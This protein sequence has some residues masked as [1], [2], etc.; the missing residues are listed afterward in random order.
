MVQSVAE[1][2]Q[3]DGEERAAIEW[4]DYDEAVLGLAGLIPPGKVL[5]YGDLAEL[6]GS[7]GPRQVGKAMSRC[8]SGVCWWRV[9]RADGSLPA[10]LQS[11]ATELWAAED[12]PQRSSGVSMKSARWQPGPAEHRLIDQ[13]AARLPIPKR[14]GELV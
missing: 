12:T 7:G 1:G 5:S 14:R 10:D 11:R 4:I 6:L 13:L 8:G 3:S 9:V 2:Q